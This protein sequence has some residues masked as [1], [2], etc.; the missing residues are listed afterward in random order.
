MASHHVSALAKFPGIEELTLKWSVL[1]GVFVDFGELGDTKYCPLFKQYYGPV[2][3]FHLDVEPCEPADFL[4][5][6]RAESKPISVRILRVTIAGR[7]WI[8]DEPDDPEEVLVKLA[9]DWKFKEP[10]KVA[11]PDMKQLKGDILAERPTLKT[12][13]IHCGHC[14]FVWGKMPD[15]QGSQFTA[16]ILPQFANFFDKNQ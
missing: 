4:A 6:M 3:A 1:S 5:K 13:C 12:L 16:N 11:L 15:G 10:A 9:I 14:V 2:A 7:P 8:Y